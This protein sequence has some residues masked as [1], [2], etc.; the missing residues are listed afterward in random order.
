MNDEQLNDL[1]EEFSSD[2]L[3]PR[4]DPEWESYL[5]FLVNGIRPDWMPMDYEIS[6][7]VRES[8]LSALDTPT[9]PTVVSLFVSSKP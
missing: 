1:P 7:E 9:S 3:D 2:L 4:N 8:V 6:D 5:N